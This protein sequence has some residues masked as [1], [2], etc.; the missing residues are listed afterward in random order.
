MD[1]LARLPLPALAHGPEGWFILARV[2]DGEAL[3]QRFAS[4]GAPMTPQR[5]ERSDVE[6][7]WGGELLLV[8]TRE[9]LGSLGRSSTSL[10]SFRRSSATAASSAK[11]FSS[12]CA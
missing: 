10:G 5:L 12:R 4:D 1:K 6:R 9:Q 3:V 11:C 8:T 2:A 7:L